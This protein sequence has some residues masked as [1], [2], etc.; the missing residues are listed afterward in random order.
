MGCLWWGFW[1]LHKTQPL[2]NRGFW[3][4]P[5]ETGEVCCR[6]VRQIQCSDW[7][8]RG[9][10]GSLC[11]QAEILWCNPTNQCSSQ[12]A[13]KTCCLPGWDH[14]GTGNH[15]QPRTQQSSRLGVVSGWRVMADML[16]NTSSNC[17]ELSGADQVCL[18][19]R[20]QP[21]VQMLPLRTL[22]YCTLQLR[23]WAVDCSDAQSYWTLVEQT[24]QPT[25]TIWKAA[26]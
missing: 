18:Q 9:K 21:Q 19:E 7:C 5:T 10:A 20:L 2:S 13:C 23:V 22:L 25:L 24:V 6:H 12:R 4:W 16:D 11:M 1:N 14:L 26:G 17:N 8:W 15:P 3:W